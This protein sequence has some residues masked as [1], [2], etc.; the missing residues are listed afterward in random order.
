MT[1]E[2]VIAPTMVNVKVKRRRPFK[3]GA[4]LSSG[5]NLV[6]VEVWEEMDEVSETFSISIHMAKQSVMHHEC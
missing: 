3:A 4:E 6:T 2:H 1:E 5:V